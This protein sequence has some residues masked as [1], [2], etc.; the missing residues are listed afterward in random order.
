MQHKNLIDIL[1][2]QS[3]VRDGDAWVVPAGVQVTVYL[4]LDEESLIIDKV[5]RLELTAD[6]AMISTQR[7]ERYA[8][9]LEGIRALRFHTDGK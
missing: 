2:R 9:E 3:A 5:T 1:G 8:V 6:L 4:S 7:R